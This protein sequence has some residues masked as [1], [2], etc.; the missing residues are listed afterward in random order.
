MQHLRAEGYSA[1]F[2]VSGA[3]GAGFYDIRSSK[4]GFDD[5]QNLG[6][7]HIFVTPE[8]LHVQFLNGSGECIHHF[9][10]D[11]AG[12]VEVLS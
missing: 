11:L 4:R 12:R 8:K 2:I 5:N 9:A 10:R 6:F 7:N 1:S 3:G